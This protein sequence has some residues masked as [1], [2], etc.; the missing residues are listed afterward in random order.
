M[1]LVGPVLI[2]V[3]LLISG[4]AT[5]ENIPSNSEPH[6]VSDVVISEP[7]RV[8]YKSELAIAKLTQIINH[9]QLE[10][11]KL[12]ELLY[13]RG[14]MYDSLGLRSLAQLDFR[15]ALEHKPDFADAYNFI[16]IHLTLMGQYAQAFEA[17]D[18]ALEIDP[19]HKY[20][21]LNRGIALHYFGRNEL[22]M[23]DFEQFYFDKPQDP[24][25][26]I[27]LYFSETAADAEGA[28]L[29]LLYNS[30]QLN[31]QDWS[32]DIVDL[33]LGNLDEQTFITNMGKNLRSQRELAERLCEGY[34][35]LAKMSLQQGNDEKAKNY[36]RL[37][38]STGVHEFVEYKYAWLE[39]NKLYEKARLEYEAALVN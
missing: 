2:A 13:D 36:F 26:A 28:R 6:F 30:T 14:V 1:K 24:Y 8:D 38:L 22:A 11:D 5:T 20:V 31:N 25:R 18:S 39:L 4:C 23:E 12:A 34:F 27:W 21:K 15:R 29:R 37:A 9:A 17:F 10:K 7:L 32:Y 3:S 33:L 16:G 35:Y 19:D